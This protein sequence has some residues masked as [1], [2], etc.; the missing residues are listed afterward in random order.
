MPEYIF[1]ASVAEM[2]LIAQFPMPTSRLDSAGLMSRFV[3]TPERQPQGKA[4][5]PGSLRALAKGAHF[6]AKLW[7]SRRFIVV[8]A[9]LD[10][11]FGLDAKSG[12]AG[13]L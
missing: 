5:Q 1:A 11:R 9:R 6:L 8:A 2:S 3:R 7:N 10:A 4:R 12:K 13:T